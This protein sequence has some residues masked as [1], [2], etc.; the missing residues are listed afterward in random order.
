M[1]EGSLEEWPPTLHAASASWTLRDQISLV[2]APCPYFYFARRSIG[3]Y[4]KYLLRRSRKRDAIVV[5][6]RDKIV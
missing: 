5:F 3:K 2:D 6:L 1:S 4:L